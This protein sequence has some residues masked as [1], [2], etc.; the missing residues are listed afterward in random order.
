MSFDLMRYREHKELGLIKVE[1]NKLI[2][3]QFDRFTGLELEPVN[4]P[5]TSEMYKQIQ[6][7][8]FLAEK[9]V[10]ECKA[11]LQDIAL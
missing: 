7:Q 9:V 6:D 1:E 8:Q 5:I 2:C 11:I 4:V 3:K 10:E